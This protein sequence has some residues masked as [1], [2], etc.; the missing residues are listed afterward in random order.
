[1]ACF[2]SPIRYTLNSGEIEQAPAKTGAKSFDS[3]YL[4]VTHLL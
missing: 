1:L 2:P 3:K 4:D